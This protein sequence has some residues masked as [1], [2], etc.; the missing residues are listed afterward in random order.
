MREECSR[1]NISG[2]T[3]QRPPSFKDMTN[4]ERTDGQGMVPDFFSD[5]I[6]RGYQKRIAGN[7][8]KKDREST[9]CNS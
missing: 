2:F 5:I 9:L 8:F 3:P 4:G 7:R 1:A 6:T